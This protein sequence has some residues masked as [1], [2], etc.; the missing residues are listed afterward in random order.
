MSPCKQWDVAN[1]TT[2]ER[3][4]CFWIIRTLILED[5]DWPPVKKILYFARPSH[6]EK[7]IQ[8]F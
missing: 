5:I 3:D 2:Q 6:V 8:V 4:L 1:Y 7:L